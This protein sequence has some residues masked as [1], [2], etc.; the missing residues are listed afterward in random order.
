MLVI[1]IQMDTLKSITSHACL[2]SSV[3]LL[4]IWTVFVGIKEVWALGIGYFPNYTWFLS[5]AN[6][7]KDHALLLTGYDIHRGYGSNSISGIAR[8]D[9][10]ITS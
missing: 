9:G 10:K 1:F 6:L 4:D 7:V 5:N 3:S 2:P 8:L